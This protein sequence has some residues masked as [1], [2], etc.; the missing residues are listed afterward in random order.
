MWVGGKTNFAGGGQVGGDLYSILNL[1]PEEF[2][3]ALEELQLPDEQRQQLETSYFEKTRALPM[4]ERPEGRRVGNIAPISYP[5]GMT[6]GEALLSGEWEFAVPEFIRGMYEAPAEAANVVSA[7]GKGTPVTK[8][9]LQEAAVSTAGIA[10][11]AAPPTRALERTVDRAQKAQY[12]RFVE[13][14]TPADSMGTAA[15]KQ[16]FYPSQRESELIAGNPTPEEQIYKDARRIAERMHTSGVSPET[17]LDS[18]GM[19]PMPLTTPIG[20]DFGTRFVAALP[21]EEMLALRPERAKNYDIPIVD[22][23]MGPR[24]AGYYEGG[25]N[26]RIGLNERLSS[27]QREKTLQHEMTHADLD[28]SNLDSQGAELGASPEGMAANKAIYMNFLDEEIKKAPDKATADLY[29]DLRK[30]LRAKTAFE[31]YELNPGE[32]LARLSEGDDSMSVRLSALETLNPYIRPK[33]SAAARGIDALTTALTSE[34]SPL[35]SRIA[36]KRPG[37]TGVYTYDAYGRVPIDISKATVTDPWYYP[38]NPS[39]N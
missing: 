35:F 4:T 37:I 29:R 15:E 7:I 8:K 31:L 18:T 1:P 33:S 36:Q 14:N 2:V 38:R 5:E 28:I 21:P 25:S 12:D 3:G 39:Q 13:R 32:M 24:S 17:I 22:E 10:T 23:A 16:F 30:K 27:E 19:V 34:T 9:Q 11:L 26:P 6:G 20:Q